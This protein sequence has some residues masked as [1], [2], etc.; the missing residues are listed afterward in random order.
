MGFASTASSSQIGQA[1]SACIDRSFSII[2]ITS[3]LKTAVFVFGQ[4]RPERFV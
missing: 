2:S 3:I 1:E 4:K